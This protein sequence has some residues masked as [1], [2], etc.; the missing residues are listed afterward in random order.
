MSQW[1]RYY[2][3]WIAICLAMG[4]WFMEP[5]IYAFV[6][7]RGSFIDRWMH[8]D[9]DELRM[10]ITVVVLM[11]LFAV[12]AQTMINRQ[13]S[14]LARLQ[15]QSQKLRQ[16]VDTA[17]DAFITM[18]ADGMIMDWNQR[19]EAI[20]GWKREEVLGGR[21]SEMI[22]PPA[23]RDTH[24]QA[25][26]RF[27]E[28]GES[29]FLN[30]QI[31]TTALRRDGQEFPVEISIVP[32]RAGN[33]Y[34]FNGFIRDISERK[35]AADRL[36][37]L[38][39][40]DM[41]TGLPNRAAFNDLLRQALA[42]AQR[43]EYMLA[44][45]FLDLDGFKSINDSLGHDAGDVLLQECALRLVQCVRDSDTVARVGGDEF[46]IILP[47]VNQAY[48]PRYVC[49]RILASL[50]KPFSIN[51]QECFIG[52]S[53]G[54]SLFP[55][56]GD[57]ADALVKHADT[58]M[59]GAKSAGKNNFKFYTSAMSAAVLKRMEMERALRHAIDKNQLSL[60]YQPQ[61]DLR[62]GS[63]LGVEALVRWHHP[64]LGTVPP[65]VFVPLAEESDLIIAIGEWVLN[66]ACRQNM[67]WQRAGLPPLRMAVNF[68]ARQFAHEGLIDSVSAALKNS[69]LEA[70][71]LEV[72]IT[73]GSA[74]RDINA[75]IAKM[76]A[77][78][79]LGVSISIDDFG[80]GFS[81]LSYLKRFPIDTLKIDRSFMLEIPKQSKDAA[82][83]T[84]IAEMAHN[85]GMQ[86]IAEGVENKEQLAF[87]RSRGC[88][89]VQGYLFSR[90]VT[91]EKIAR[92]LER[93]QERSAGSRASAHR[94]A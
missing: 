58:A 76:Q 35:Q 34:I 63:I 87:L 12:Y 62:N 64:A 49:E 28:S 20:F 72:E 47:D 8:P 19:A 90:P 44:V 67:A 5:S 57:S 73:E 93:I 92:M 46:L 55:G 69:G 11:L 79:S 1:K 80:T 23:K 37:H 13:Q 56:D 74:M 30:R 36:E 81:S 39:H 22:V 85:L 42:L 17:H 53:I 86:V 15:E 60:L 43:N 82:I 32:L 16:I 75:S 25:I 83:V 4:F 3:V 7:E 54:V 94:T 84:T 2:M 29:A 10:R 52:A 70:K 68:A 6:L 41:L 65:S 24:E 18:D 50:G 27:L 31:E 61:V 59:Y 51:G 66:A 26:I 45:M 77:L 14:V 91:A 78:K 33:T 89:V 71:Y 21:L 88:D 48:G 9:P 38:A 40:R